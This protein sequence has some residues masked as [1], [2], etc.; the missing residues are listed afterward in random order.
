[1]GT[2]DQTGS[3]QGLLLRFDVLQACGTWRRVVWQI[4]TNGGEPAAAFFRVKRGGNI[5]LRNVVTSVPNYT[6]SRPRSLQSLEVLILSNRPTHPHIN[7]CV[8]WSNSKPELHLLFF[9][10]LGW[11]ETESTWYVGH[12]LGLSYLPRMM[13]CVEQSVEW[14]LAGETEVLGEI[15]LQCHFV[16]HKSHMAWDRTRAAAVGSRRLTAWAMERPSRS[17][18][19]HLKIQFLP[20]RKPLYYRSQPV[21]AVCGKSRCLLWESYGTLKYTV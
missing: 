5:L 2:R 6:V 7:I 11:G 20:H 19:Y 8:I 14:T 4:V 15:L 21:N 13:M 9:N 1:M 18:K 16:H 12:Y 10:F 17:P 3:M